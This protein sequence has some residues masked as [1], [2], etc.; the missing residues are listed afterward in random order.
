MSTEVTHPTISVAS[1]K[2]LLLL[3][4]E[5]KKRRWR[6]MSAKARFADQTLVIGLPEVHYFW[7]NNTDDSE[8]I[9]L[10]SMG[11]T[12]VKEPQPQEVLSGKVKP[13]IT[14]A[15]LKEDGTYVRGDV[16]LMQV[17]QEDYEFFL[18]DIEQ[19][20]EEGMNSVKTEFLDSAAQQ[21]VPTFEIDRSKK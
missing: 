21:G 5:E 7:A 16:I 4:P 13:K 18:L 17:P 8:L 15:G 3:S 20:H 11:Y 14:A 9:R 10:Q 2:P 6:E 1:A 12:I 19:R